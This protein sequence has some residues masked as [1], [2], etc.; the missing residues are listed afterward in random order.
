MSKS[1]SLNLALI[2]LFSA[3]TCE[4]GPAAEELLIADDVEQVAGLQGIKLIPRNPVIGAGGD[5][6]FALQDNTMILTVA[7]Q[8]SSMYERWK[9]EEGF[10][11]AAVTGIGDEAFNGPSFGEYRYV[12][13][14]RKGKT[15]VSLSSF[16]NMK[17][18]GEPYLNQE[19]LQALAKIM[20]SRI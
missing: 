13:I 12:L 10:F 2:L 11:H 9:G 7:V 17:A 14:F 1:L 15:A 5:L 8:D 3:F 19:E 16:I 20:I 6:N 4:V 18:G